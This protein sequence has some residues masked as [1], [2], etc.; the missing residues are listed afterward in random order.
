MTRKALPWKA[1][2]PSRVLGCPSLNR[3]CGFL[4]WRR[5]SG[6]P[7]L[8]SLLVSPVLWGQGARNASFPPI[9]TTSW[10]LVPT[11]ERA[12]LPDQ[13]QAFGLA[14]LQPLPARTGLHARF[15]CMGLK[16]TPY[17]S[18]APHPVFEPRERKG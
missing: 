14:F 1:S 10:A 3:G 9:L 15:S 13:A 11:A 18:C 5:G 8:C 2:C 17:P 6:E 4:S 7:G 16:R 12:P